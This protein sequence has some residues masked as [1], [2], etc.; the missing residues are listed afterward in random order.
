LLS[1]SDKRF[2]KELSSDPRWN[3]VIDSLR[4]TPPTY[5]PD[6]D[7]EDEKLKSKFIYESGMFNEN[8]RVIKIL[9]QGIE[10]DANRD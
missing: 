4:K 1:D 7:I 6:D 2:L 3:R 9:T 5:R 8:S 10:N